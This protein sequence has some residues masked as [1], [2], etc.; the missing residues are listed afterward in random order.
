MSIR[1]RAADLL[2]WLA[3]RLD[4]DRALIR[5]VRIPMGIPLIPDRSTHLSYMDCYFIGGAR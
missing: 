1:L 3:F 4:P 2:L 5:G